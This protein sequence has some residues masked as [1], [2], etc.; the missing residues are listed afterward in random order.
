MH[1]SVSDLTI[2]YIPK[3]ATLWSPRRPVKISF[4]QQIA[5]RRFPHIWPIPTYTLKGATGATGATVVF[6]SGIWTTK[7]VLMPYY[8]KTS[9][10]L[11]KW[12]VSRSR[13]YCDT[14][15]H[16][17]THCNTL[18]HTA[19]HWSQS[20]TH[21]ATHCNTLQHAATLCN[22]LQHTGLKIALILQHTATHCNTIQHAATHCVTTWLWLQTTQHTAT[23][24]NVL[25]RAAKHYNRLQHTAT[26]CDTLQHTLWQLDFDCQSRSSRCNTLQ[27]TATR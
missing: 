7:T 5:M 20:R 10:K 16:T 14:L 19:T 6:V 2:Q 18:Q 27:P 26:C 3:F 24:C 8:W 4:S 11:S 25:R 1:T 13:S 15:Q 21:A 17:A 23:F 9:A 12:G 22:T